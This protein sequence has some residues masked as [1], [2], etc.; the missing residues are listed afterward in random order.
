MRSALIFHLT[1]D[2][3]KLARDDT[4]SIGLKSNIKN[5]YFVYPR[6]KHIFLWLFSLF[7]FII[8]AF[9]NTVTYEVHNFMLR[10]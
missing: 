1:L 6:K 7:G 3:A 5:H 2:A 9:A 8:V 4:H 10:H